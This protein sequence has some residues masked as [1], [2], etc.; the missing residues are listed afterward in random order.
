MSPSFARRLSAVLDSPGTRLLEREGGER[1]ISINRLVAGGLVLLSTVVAAVAR[2]VFSPVLTATCLSYI[3]AGAILFFDVRRRPHRS[4]LRRYLCLCLDLGGIS[5]AVSHLTPYMA[6]WSPMYLWVVVGYAFRYGISYLRAAS[7]LSLACFI[8]VVVT[9]PFWNQQPYVA[10]GLGVGLVIIPAYVEALLRK[11]LA[12]TEQMQATNR[13]KSFILSCVSHDL[14]MPLTA[15]SGM[16]DMLSE[17]LLDPEQQTMLDAMRSAVRSILS[18][19]EALLDVSRI[20][21]GHSTITMSKFR[22][23]GLVHEIVGLVGAEARAKGLQLG[24]HITASTPLVIQTDRRHLE[25]ILLNLVSNAV[26]FTS[27]G[28]VLISV[29][30]AVSAGGLPV[31][32]IEVTD[33]GIGIPHH[34]RTEVFDAY[35][36]VNEEVLSQHRGAGLGL[37]IA[38]QLVELLDGRISV[39]SN[40]GVGSTF[41]IEVPIQAVGLP[42][43][44]PDLSKIVVV[45]VSQEPDRVRSL[46][47]RLERLGAETLVLE[48]SDQIS[49][50]LASD[51]DDDQRVVMVLDGQGVDPVVTAHAIRANT[52][53]GRVPLVL[54]A[55]TRSLP[56]LALRRH[57]ITTIAA[58][59]SDNEIR[60]ALQ[61]VEPPEPDSRSAMPTASD[62][63]LPPPG[64][65]PS[66]PSTAAQPPPAAGPFH[67]LVADDNR[68]NQVVLT[69]WLVQ[70]GHTVTA[71]DE[72]EAALDA[73]E[74][75]DFDLAIM[76]LNMP[77]MSGAEATQLYRLISSDRPRLP[78]IGLTAEMTP[79]AARRCASAGMD[80]CLTKPV[81]RARLLEV[82][83]Q[84]ARARP[85]PTPPVASPASNPDVTAISSHP[86]FRP[87]LG[88]P[89][90]DEFNV[91]GDVSDLRTMREISRAFRSDAATALGYLTAAV[92]NSDAR[93]FRGH[94]LTLRGS[95]SAISAAR[96]DALCLSSSQVDADDFRAKGRDLLVQ[97]SR[98][99]DRVC[100]SL[101]QRSR[102]E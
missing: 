90:A 96:L 74:S 75:N 18:D 40:V 72:G 44:R 48:Q 99:I 66:I 13:A 82:I 78:I 89:P 36:Q 93:S 19:M 30:G 47:S 22:I 20:E 70:A 61:I 6:I 16:A 54:L 34:T 37:T 24:M 12:A 26:K 91:L 31:L 55:A 68:T 49:A 1:E 56:P 88:P 15:M 8:I 41:K 25:R 42:D 50:A 100:E 98:E 29:D 14:R 28:S 27:V 10:L 95:A 92:A 84:A 21:A 86:L 69:H 81:D 67:V 97:F 58:T 53:F 11:A 94:V 62:P 38:K 39:D 46:A 83:S 60:T 76:D 7:A 101:E 65:G 73:L 17:T 32:S 63:A 71:V 33:T 51:L 85:V 57:F 43:H 45:L 2:G 102:A 77:G 59:S 35:A 79:E 64:S 9:T 23:V 87:G 80:I 5:V 52:L 3:C 4:P